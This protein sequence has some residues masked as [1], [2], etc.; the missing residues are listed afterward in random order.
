MSYAP[1]PA[2]LLPAFS[3]DWRR[4][5][6][7]NL[8][9]DVGP[10][11]WSQHWWPTARRH[12]TTREVQALANTPFGRR[13]PGAQHPLHN[14]LAS[15]TGCWTSTANRNATASSSG[16]IERRLPADAREFTNVLSCQPAGDHISGMPD[17]WL[18]MPLE[19]RL[20]APAFRRARRVEVQMG[21]QPRRQL[22]DQPAA[23][24][25][26]DPAW[27]LHR[28][29]LLAGSSNDFY[30]TANNSSHNKQ[31]ARELW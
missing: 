11:P 25:A 22:R 19:F 29:V 17:N 2:R 28:W 6:A 24:Q 12:K 4:W 10:M 15:A 7:E 14:R 23:A 30:M 20:P 18:A 31:A 1:A 9:L 13:A 5:V 8:M 21:A 27:R 3:D 26:A 16:A